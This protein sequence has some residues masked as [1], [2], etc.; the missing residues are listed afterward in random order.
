MPG[1]P[2]PLCESTLSDVIDTRT[3]DGL[4]VRKRKCFNGH[5]YRTEETAADVPPA[6]TV[7]SLLLEGKSVEEI[8]ALTGRTMKHVRSMQSELKGIRNGHD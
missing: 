3:L 8:A 5:V 1:I 7:R 4:V 2:C 6:V